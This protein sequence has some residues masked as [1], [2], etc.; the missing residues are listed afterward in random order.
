MIP[1]GT[2]HTSTASGTIWKAVTCDGCA[3]EFAYRMRRSAT[4][5][6]MNLAFLDP[7]A[8]RRAGDRAA[9]ALD[10]AL[11]DGFDAVPCPGCGRYQAYMLGRVPVPGRSST[12][13]VA[14]AGACLAGSVAGSLVGT[15]LLGDPV[16]PFLRDASPVVVGALVGACGLA[17]LLGIAMIFLENR[18]NAQLR[19]SF[20]P[21]ADAAARAGKARPDVVLREAYE[22]AFAEAST[23]GRQ[24]VFPLRWDPP[25]TP[26]PTRSEPFVAPAPPPVVARRPPPPP[27]PPKRS[28]S[29]RAGPP[30]R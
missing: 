8:A 26:G 22:A 17:V 5:T 19:A 3:L 13:G 11:L 6:G 4:G 21:N 7:D 28:L 12:L 25:G 20:D 15:S 2:H 29:E 16:L 27:P 14:G 10:Q 23:Q 1:I 18:Q 24:D 30:K 9:H